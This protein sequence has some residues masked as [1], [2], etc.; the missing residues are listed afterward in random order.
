MQNVERR[1]SFFNNNSSYITNNYPKSNNQNFIKNSSKY[2]K[3]ASLQYSSNTQYQNDNTKRINNPNN[4]NISYLNHNHPQI[5]KFNSSSNLLKNSP[6]SQSITN[7]NSPNPSKYFSPLQKNNIENINYI[8]LNL[9]DNNTNIKSPLYKTKINNID[10]KKT[11]NNSNKINNNKKALILDLDETLVHSGFHP[12]NRKSDFTLDINIDGKNH[13]IYVLKRPYVDEFLSEISPFFEII[14]FTASIPEYASPVMDQLDKGNLAYG[15]KFRQDCLFN[16]GLYL[17]DLKNIGQNLKDVIIIDNNPVS[18]ALNQENGIPILTWYEDLNDK[19]LINLIPLLKYLSTVNDVRPII[20]QIVDRQKNIIN[21]E[22]VEYF[23]KNK[24][25]ENNNYKKMIYETND[26]CKEN[27]NLRNDYRE[28]KNNNYLDNKRNYNNEKIY[29]F[30]KDDINYGKEKDRLNLNE[31]ENNKYKNYLFN[32]NLYKYNNN[33]HDSLS[34]MTYNEIQNEGQVNNNSNYCK[35]Y[36]DNKENK[37]NKDYNSFNFFNEKEK[38]AYQNKT[39]GIMDSQM[40]QKKNLE[41]MFK[42]I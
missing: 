23:I 19:E 32:E 29:K 21:F 17:K 41:I 40:Q 5:N 42:T 38:N 11:K 20:K 6:Y 35:N 24:I 14:F 28:N 33:I 4:T 25:N 39:N 12:F 26:N 36:N 3:K 37:E 16:H 22:L 31:N 7:L 34:N 10:N 1:N 27:T 2:N 15:R 13:T 9:E 18:Y 8:N 30:N